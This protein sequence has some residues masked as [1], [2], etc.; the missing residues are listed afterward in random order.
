MPPKLSAYAVNLCFN[1]L[2]MAKL[3]KVKQVIEP[4]LNGLVWYCLVA[5]LAIIVNAHYLNSLLGDKAA[6]RALPHLTST[7]NSILVWT[8]NEM[9]NHLGVST[10][11]NLVVGLT[12]GFIGLLVYVLCMIAL[13]FF[14]HLIE[15]YETKGYVRPSEVS[16]GRQILVPLAKLL[17]QLVMAVVLFAYFILLMAP[18]M[19]GYILP[20]PTHNKP[21]LMAYLLRI[22]IYVAIIH[23]FVLILRLL[24]LHERLGEQAELPDTHN[25]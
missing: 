23:G 16:G 21:I 4:S 8:N 12:W 17:F 10:S 5:L 9:L 3:S 1:E 19:L 24:F 20:L 25:L 7:F 15:I 18:V 6:A 11:N 2:R 22:V 13:G 14:K